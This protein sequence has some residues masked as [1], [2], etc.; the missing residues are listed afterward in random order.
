MPHND[1]SNKFDQKLSQLFDGQLS[2]TE[3][4]ELEQSL[5]ENPEARQTYFNYV[6]INTGINQH[7]VERLKVLDSIVTLD[8]PQSNPVSKKPVSKRNQ[9]YSSLFSYCA[10]AAASVALILFVETFMMKRFFWEQSLPEKATSTGN[11]FPDTYVATLVRSTDCQWGND[12][13]P[14]FSGQRLLSKDLILI[15]GIAEFRF[16]SGIRLVL[17]GPT[18]LKIKS[19]NSAEMI[20]GSVVLHGYESAPEFEL[21]TSQA[22]FFDVGTE[23]GIKVTENQGTELHVFEGAVRIQPNHNSS[24]ENSK[25]QIV[26]Q[27]I[28]QHLK[29]QTSK[30]IAL[31]PEKFQ[32]NVPKKD[33]QQKDSREALIAYDGFQ[34]H[35]KS[36]QNRFMSWQH[37]GTGWRGPWRN[38]RLGLQNK[39]Q[40]ETHVLKLSPAINFPKKTLLSDLQSSNQTGCVQFKKS[41]QS[42]RTLKKPLRLDTDAVYFFSLFFE[43]STPNSK[44]TTLNQYGNI[45]FR[46]LDDPN[47]QKINTNNI[48]F[49]ISS[50]NN[51][52]LHTPFETVRKAPPISY[53]KPYLF[54]GKI[55]ASKNSPDQVFLRVFSQSEKIPKEE[56]LIWTCISAPYDDATVY[57]QV[58]FQVG[59]YSSFFFDE[60]RIGTTWESVTNFQPP[61]ENLK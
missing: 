61:K 23:Y 27:G 48:L 9:K 38:W 6:D 37:T 29:N 60:L 40:D 33:I 35:R 41:N 10:V 30:K 19:A 31:E 42:W 2:Q 18:R 47:N 22:K 50:D 51:T 24:G 15:E 7:T 12:N 32:R 49:G 8:A 59:K 25:V 36:D 58:R 44:K 57:D 53:D 3:F 20:S 5:L 11:E 21:I 39:E 13:R 43:K 4:E 28:A 34:I 56:P 16:D 54:I 17:E 52:T 45:S 1:P 46:T 55:V 26:N 14:L